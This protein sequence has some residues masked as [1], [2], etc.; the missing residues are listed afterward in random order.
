MTVHGGT[1][2]VTF[3]RPDPREYEAQKRA[4]MAQHGAANPAVSGIQEVMNQGVGTAIKAETSQTP[5]G[6]SNI[7]PNELMQGAN[8]NFAQND[9]PGNR[10]LEDTMNQTGNAQDGVSNTTQNQDYEDMESGALEKRMKLYERA[11]GNADASLND[12]RV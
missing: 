2:K 3:N 5:Y 6:N 7:M 4:A 8:S 1:Q 10:P 9:V 12:R 11:V